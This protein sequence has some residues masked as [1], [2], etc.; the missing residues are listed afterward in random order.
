MLKKLQFISIL[1][2][3]AFS[4][5]ATAQATFQHSMGLNINVSKDAFGA[6]YMYS[7]RVNLLY[8]G[9]EGSFSVGTNLQ[10]GFGSGWSNKYMYNSP[11]S[12]MIDFPLVANV[13][14]GHAADEDADSGFGAYAGVGFG[15]NRVKLID[16]NGNRAPLNVG[17]YFDAG[18]RF[19]LGSAS[20]YLHASYLR[21]I[22][23][24]GASVLSLGT[25]YTFGYW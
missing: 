14:I 16:Y 13:N 1:C 10:L 6:C 20:M 18:L 23:S 24:G 25:G 12:L 19:L 2:L 15:L 21:N 22:Q 5:K 7:P 8:F 9:Y 3:V 11:V 17:P 4:Q